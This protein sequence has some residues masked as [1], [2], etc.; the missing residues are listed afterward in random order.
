MNRGRP[1]TRKVQTV[2]TQTLDAS[3]ADCESSPAGKDLVVVGVDGSGCALHAARWAAQEADRRSGVLQLVHAYSLPP[4]GYSGYNPYPA[5]VLAD[6]REHG[7]ATLQDAKNELRRAYPALDVRTRMAYGDP[8]T[9]VHQGST[10]AQLTVVG[11]H[12]SNRLRVAL[13]SVAASVAATNP[14]PVAVIHPG[15]APGY[16]PVVVGIDGSPISEEAISF[17]FESAAL[18][19]APL[20][21]VHC[22]TDR[23]L[24]GPVPSSLAVVV[25]EAQ[26][27]QSERIL[28]AERLAGWAEKYPD[29]M[30]EQ[31]V[32]HELPIP[33]L[34]G[35]ARTA[36]LIVVGSRGHSGLAGLLLGSTSQALIA[37][38]SC[39]IVVVRPRTAD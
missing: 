8:A 35:Y 25:D 10:G 22:W 31:A 29:V 16:G 28:L 21:A 26:F 34:L 5:G 13:G 7:R 19:G 27:G 32:I 15:E 36:Q 4:A 6:L 39:P 14:A 12:G 38:S 11:A 9:V 3:T 33:T 24:D 2:S 20:I 23:T 18:R 30:V 17:A 1:M 37:R